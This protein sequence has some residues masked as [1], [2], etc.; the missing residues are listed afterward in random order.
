MCTEDRV[1]KI[2]LIGRIRD[3]LEDERIKGIK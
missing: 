1:L 3:N 2:Y